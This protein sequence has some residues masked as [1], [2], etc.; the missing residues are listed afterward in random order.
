MKIETIEISGFAS[1]CKA[2]RLPFGKEPRSKHLTRISVNE[3]NIRYFGNVTI[4]PNDI[5]LLSRLVKAGDCEAKVLRGIVVYTEITAPIYFWREAETYR[6]GHERL[7][8]EST[9]HIDCR[10][11]AGEELQ[12]AKAE[13]PM[14]KEC[15]CVDG[16]SYQ[17]LRNIYIWRHNHRLPEWR[18]FC[19]WIETLPFAKELILFGLEE[20]KRD[21]EL[22]TD[23][24]NFAK[25]C[26]DLTPDEFSEDSDIYRHRAVSLAKRIRKYEG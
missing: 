2:L 25:D 20:K 19:N 14:G 22:F 8:S 7:S 16:W 3:N 18:E 9:M 4:D 5:N 21:A 6:H 26:A 24:K 1:V 23:L 15:S 11:L 12:K 17:V 10:G 13:I